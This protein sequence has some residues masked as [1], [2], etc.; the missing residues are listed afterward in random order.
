MALLVLTLLG[1][2]AARCD[3]IDR[4]VATVN[5]HIILQSDW[6]EAL[7]LEAFLSNRN[8]SQFS[9]DE[10]R[11][12]LDRLIDQQLLREQMKSA[13]FNRATD[14]EVS[15]RLADT[16]KQYPQAASDKGCFGSAKVTRGRK[17]LTL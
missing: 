8:P 7:C 17:R 1:P 10:R 13:E 14:T 6:D 9:D 5:G 4:I 12:V 16:R 2:I 11:A 3:V 15:A